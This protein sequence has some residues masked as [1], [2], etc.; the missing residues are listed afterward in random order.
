MFSFLDIHFIKK[1]L[2]SLI[3]S[4]FEKLFQ[5]ENFLFF[6]FS[7]EKKIFLKYIFGKAIFLADKEKNKEFFINKNERIKELE[8][9]IE[10]FFL[11]DIQIYIGERVIDFIF[12]GFGKKRI[13]RFQLFGKGNVVV[14]ETNE[15]NENK[16][17]FNLN[18][19]DSGLKKKLNFELF[20]HEINNLEMSL[21]KILS[22]FFGFGKYYFNEF[23]ARYNFNYSKKGNELNKKEKE[24]LCNKIKEFLEQELSPFL[25]E[26]RPFPIK[27]ITQK[28]IKEYKTYSE[29]LDDYF[30][31]K[32]K[33]EKEI[34]N[35]EKSI[36]KIQENVEEMEKEALTY[37]EM[38]NLIYNYYSFFEELINLYEKYKSNKKIDEFFEKLKK[39]GFKIENNCLVIDFEELKKLLK[40]I[41]GY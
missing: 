34:E 33:L 21:E 30:K 37:E 36:K 35:L 23:K 15:L 26:K 9:L 40:T 11:K 38:G 31:P 29:A 14:F 25:G 1:E 2:G 12:E 24:E 22:N 10:R 27:M 13:L 32:S 17:I 20:C 8:S 41:Y 28:V 16:E 7:K 6:Q 3:G 18:N 5:G 19:L 39:K 4:R